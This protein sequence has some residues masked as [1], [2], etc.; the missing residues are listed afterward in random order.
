[1]KIVL[2]KGQQ[3]YFTSDTHYS[4]S[5]IC[6]STSRWPESDKTRDFETL[7][8]MDN[9]IVDNINNVVGEDDHLFHLGDW[10]FGGFEKIREFRER[11]I[12]KNVHI[13][14]G[15]HDHHIDRDKE[16]IREIFSS[17]NDYVFLTVVRQGPNPNKD[18]STKDRFVLCHFPIASWNGLSDGVIHLH[19]HVH[20]PPNK[21][22]ADGRAMD[23]G[24]DGNYLVPYS[25]DEVIDLL[26][27]RNKRSL[28]LPN[29]HHENSI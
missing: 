4:H 6:R 9:S 19:G 8:H 26:K 23:V 28:R 1:M 27:D 22:I 3:I 10:S 14:L 24:M 16:G 12:C 15:N 13:V 18:K 11:I 25:L 5:N 7:E 20:L 21:K 2:N 17:V 29:D